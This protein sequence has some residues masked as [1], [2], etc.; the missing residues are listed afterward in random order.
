MGEMEL[1]RELSTAVALDDGD[2]VTQL[3][4]NLGEGNRARFSAFLTAFFYAVVEYQFRA[5]RTRGAVVRFVDHMRDTRAESG[6]Q[7][8]PLIVEGVIRAVLGEEHLL[9]EIPPNEQVMYEVPILQHIFVQSPPARDRMGEFLDSAEAMLG[10][11]T[12]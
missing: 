4:A 11:T 7:L 10:K 9:D 3:D 6:P 2:K 1:Y 8:K 5:D 12:K